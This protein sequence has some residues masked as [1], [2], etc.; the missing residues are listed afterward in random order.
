[1][2]GGGVRESI[3]KLSKEMFDAR[4]RDDR[5]A[6]MAPRLGVARHLLKMLELHHPTAP[7]REHRAHLSEL[8]DPEGAKVDD[9]DYCE[10]TTGQSP[11]VPGKSTDD[12][13]VHFVTARDPHGRGFYAHEAGIDLPADGELS[14]NTD[15]FEVLCSQMRLGGLIP[16]L[17]SAWTGGSLRRLERL[18]EGLREARE[19][20]RRQQ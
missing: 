13:M 4:E 2:K 20:A 19:R 8:E 5:G 14:R 15:E 7:L 18:V 16:G 3:R 12:W 11:T 1:M 10:T 6:A 17:A 9:M